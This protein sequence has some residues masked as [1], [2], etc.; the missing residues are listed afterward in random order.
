[1]KTNK[2][3]GLREQK[4][5]LTRQH[6]SNEATKLFIRYGFDNVTISDI[7]QAA[8]VS[9]MTVSNY[10]V[11]KEELLFDRMGE[12]TELLEESLKN[13]KERSP[14]AKLKGLTAELLEQKHKVF[15]IN[16]NVVK[17]WQVV[18]DST[19]LS[20]FGIMQFDIICK[21]LG[22]MLA[23]NVGQPETDPTAHLLATIIM[24]T[25]RIAYTEALFRQKMNIE[26]TDI[27][28]LFD[29]TARGFCAAEV[30]AKG[31]QYL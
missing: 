15:M 24:N 6:I 23:S 7:A 29:I 16:Q 12:I 18:S 21:Q 4:K 27:E 25:W 10:F 8:N 17:F 22:K 13:R 26:Q 30:A 14:L 31:T 9:K 1:M 20:T 28:F 2:P 11:R 3:E 5:R 19:T